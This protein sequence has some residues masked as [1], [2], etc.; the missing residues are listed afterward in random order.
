MNILGL[1]I[2][3]ANIKAADGTGRALC[4]PFPIW[5]HP[6]RLADH[7]QSIQR[8][9]PRTEGIAVTM[10]AELADCFA[11]K[12]Q[13]VHSILNSVVASADAVPFLVW[14]TEGRF[15]DIE[16]AI[17]LPM[18]VAAANWHVLAT[19]I[20]R[21]APSDQISLL[22]D[23]GTTTTD[24][25][26]ISAG[27]PASLGTTDVGRLMHGE[28]CYSGIRRTPL[29]AIANSVPFRDGYCPLA[30]ELFATS[31]DVYLLTGEIAE[32]E[33]DLE[34]A[35]GGPA[36]IAAAYDRIARSLCG[37][38]DEVSLEEAIQIARFIAD[39]QRQRLAGALERVLQRLPSA[40]TRVV[41]SGA[42]AFLARKLIAGNR[43]LDRA[44]VESLD[45]LLSPEIAEAACAHAV[46]ML[47]REHVA[48]RNQ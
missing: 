48:A 9:F 7:L 34:T 8:E 30:A 27:L 36:T 28:L 10:T 3:G 11:T 14:T 29:C 33:C 2:G 17:K 18:L 1:D 37:D 6:E 40:C 4:R 35:N 24:F 21:T 46:A 25:I 31:L 41:A 39:V 23:I 19:W 13:G 38:R 20:G 26:L 5:K 22:I 43:R 16:Q 32:D 44:T 12:A 15:V 45:D 42:G 47:A